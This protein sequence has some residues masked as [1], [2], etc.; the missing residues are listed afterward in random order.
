MDQLQ[1]QDHPILIWVDSQISNWENQL[2]CKQLQE[3]YQ[4][5]FQACNDISQA[6]ELLQNIGDKDITILTSGQCAYQ[7]VKHTKQNIIVFC[8]RRQNH[9]DLFKNNIQIKSIVSD[10]FLQAHED[11]IMSMNSTC[12]H[13]ISSCHRRIK[14]KITLTESE[15]FAEIENLLSIGNQQH[16]KHAI[17]KDLENKSKEKLK[18]T[19]QKFQLF[20]KL[21]YLYTREEI[22]YTFNQQFA[23]HN[24]QSIKN[25]ILCLYQGFKE[26]YNNTNQFQILYRGIPFYDEDIFKQIMRDLNQSKDEGSSLF[27]I[28]FLAHLNFYGILYNIILDQEIPHPCFNLQQYSKYPEEKE[29]I[30]F[31]QFEFIV[32]EIQQQQ[33]NNQQVYTVTIKQVRNNYAFALDPF[34][35][36]TYWDSVFEQKIKPKIETLVNFQCK[37]I[38]EFLQFC[39]Y[40]Q[41]NQGLNQ[42]IFVSSIKKEFENAFQQIQNQLIKIFNDSKHPDILNQIKSL[43]RTYIEVVKF[44]YQDDLSSNQKKFLGEI[45]EIMTSLK[46]NICKL[47]LK[48]IIN[49]EEE[50]EYLQHLQK[51]FMMN[52]TKVFNKKIVNP[53]FRIGSS[54]FQ[55]PV[56]QG[57]VV[58]SFQQTFKTQK[59][60]SVQQAQ[61][62]NGILGYLATLQ[63]G[64]KLLMYHNLNN[65]E[66][67]FSK[68]IDPN[69]N[70]WLTKTSKL[71]KISQNQ[72]KQR[73][74]PKKMQITDRLQHAKASGQICG[75]IAGAVGSVAVDFMIDGVNQENLLL[76]ASSVLVQGGLAYASSV[77]SLEKVGPYVGIGINAL[78]VGKSVKDVL[79][80]DFLSQSE[81]LY[82][83]ILITTKAGSALG[84]SCLGIEGGKALGVPQ[85]PPGVLLGGLIGGFVGGVAGNFLGRAIDNYNQFSLE[86]NFSEKNKSNR[87]NGYL[88]DPGERPLFKWQ[89]VKDKARSLILIGQTDNHLACLITNISRDKGQIYPQED[90]G[91]KQ[92]LYNY[93]GPDDS[94]SKITFRLIAITQEYINDHEVLN[95]FMTNQVNYIDMA[96]RE[97]NLKDIR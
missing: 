33:N 93:I 38:F 45:N 57:I 46:L 20:E 28:Q 19:K 91:I 15:V 44:E 14:K 95:L 76:G 81:K 70:I 12:E 17:F 29:V 59:V 9:F 75:Q 97:I 61:H 80:S 54:Q 13:L 4:N 88:I 53:Q 16:K 83:S 24:Y 40:E 79:V 7:L 37:R 34:K 5:A 96:V 36:K 49:I 63:D 74:Q 51:Y 18:S 86:V 62:K 68:M 3:D 50:K 69:S 21:I 65:Y 39:T 26:H 6:C 55:K 84:I 31:P 23:Q 67:T 94:N 32:Q 78:I 90:V 77:K 89:C 25:I 87:E 56:S 1:K 47:V 58:Q 8:G 66:L 52:Q 48:G 22:Y 82:N 60:N 41:I 10:S 73:K 11:A 30:L 2:Y 72:R 64:N 42:K 92:Q 27:G 43:T 35:R 85:G 71:T